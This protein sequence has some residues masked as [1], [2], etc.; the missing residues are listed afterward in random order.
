MRWNPHLAAVFPYWMS[1][2]ASVFLINLTRETSSSFG[3][4]CWD[5]LRMLPHTDTDMHIN[6]QARRHHSIGL[7]VVSSVL[8]FFSDA[9]DWQLTECKR[10][11][12][13]QVKWLHKSTSTS[14]HFQW[15][16]TVTLLKACMVDT[17]SLGVYI[18]YKCTCM[19][20]LLYM[21]T[22][23]C[24]KNMYACCII[25]AIGV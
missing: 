22:G 3:L 17:N 11:S 20:K 23:I 16:P 15:Y 1:R 2:A 12:T 4:R 10:Y 5:L 7:D 8:S 13:K 6:I 24:E 9:H 18:T 25:Y 14:S 19:C 21:Y